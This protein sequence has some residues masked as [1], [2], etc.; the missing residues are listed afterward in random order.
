MRRYKRERERQ[1]TQLIRVK[2]V[3]ILK[4]DG[5]RETMSADVI[6]SRMKLRYEVE[7]WRSE[8]RERER[9]RE[10]QRDDVRVI[11]GRKSEERDGGRGRCRTI[12]LVTSAPFDDHIF[13]LLQNH[14]RVVVKV[15][16]HDGG[17][18][19]RGTARLRHRVRVHQVHQSLYDCV[20]RRVHVRLE[21]KRALSVTVEG[22]VSV[23]SDNPIL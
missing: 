11:A 1:S 7:R 19:G 3:E 16:H 20:I 12:R 4:C 10:R 23:W 21:R 9:E 2:I 6:V 5:R 17:Q 8:G 22:G 18:F 14:V 13:V 15:E